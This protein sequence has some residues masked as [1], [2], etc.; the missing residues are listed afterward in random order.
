MVRSVEDVCGKY[1]ERMRGLLEAIDLGRPGLQKVKQAYEKGALADACS[2]LLDYYRN[3]DSG[4]WLVPKTDAN[5][6]VEDD[7]LSTKLAGRQSAHA[8]TDQEI[9]QEA[10]AAC[11]DVLTYCWGEKSHVPRR[12]DGHLDWDCKGPSNDPEW[13]WSLNRHFLVDALLDAYAR[14]NNPKYVRKID[15]SLRDWVIASW[16]YP[17]KKSS[18]AMW[19]GLEVNFR[20]QVWGRTFYRL[21]NNADFSPAARLLLLSS[22]PEHAHYLRN[23]HQPGSNWL[24]ME[25]S[26][27]AMAGAAWPEFK[28]SRAWLEY[29]KTTLCP[30]IEKQV[31]PDGVQTELT[32]HYHLVSLLNFQEFAKTCRHAHVTLPGDFEKRLQDMWSYLADI[33]PPNGY[34]PINNDSSRIL[35]R[36]P[37]AA[38]AGVYGRED[39]LYVAT[40][41]REG[42]MPAGPP[43]RLLPW[44]GQLIS[45]S[46]YDAD[47]QWSFFDVGPWGS[48]HQH[49]DKLHLSVAAFGREFLVDSGIFAY[50]GALATKFRYTYAV[51]STGHNV[52]LVDGCGQA[53]GPLRADHPLPKTDY[54]IEKDFDYARG[55]VDHFDKA[56]GQVKHTRA[57]V[58]VR[59]AFWAVVDRIETDRPRDIETLWHWHPTCTVTTN[60]LKGV[61]ASTDPGMGNLAIVPAGEIDWRV[62]I[63]KG[64]EKPSI[65]G[66][67][68][69]TYGAPEPS[70]T[71]VYAAHINGSSTFAWVLFPAKGPVPRVDAELTSEDAECASVRVVVSKGARFDVTVPLGGER[72]AGVTRL[73]E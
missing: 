39:W 32:S 41:G 28:D 25:M 44:A 29:A 51:P 57:M 54:R 17:A 16:P 35:L 27:L 61:V 58:Y 62:Q 33:L 18:T 2:A 21:Q 43:S 15:E 30:Q 72:Q 38:A 8:P 42:K 60:T 65:Q 37:V 49:N 69:A 3:G 68:S 73:R 34:Q 67:Y 13:A 47:A 4:A 6:R 7:P 23:F 36:A 5:G 19:R 66:W 12:A 64:Q 11:E 59:G 50:S 71:A 1:P 52:I 20:I 26:G 14:T 10:D 45:R 46:G 9:I 63:V 56:E 22:V 48:A 70:P 55:T 40:N 31:Y 53:A 24:T